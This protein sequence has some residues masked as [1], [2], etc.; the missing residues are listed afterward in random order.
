[1]LSMVY[2]MILLDQGHMNCGY[3]KLEN[4]QMS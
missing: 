1:M 2:Q 3:K 4:F